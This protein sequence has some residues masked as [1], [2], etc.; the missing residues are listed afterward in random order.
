MSHT[1]VAKRY[2]EAL[3]QIGV[4]KGQLDFLETELTTVREVFQTNEELLEFLTHPKVDADQKKQL[5]NQ[6]FEGFSKD[7]IHTLSLLVDRHNESIVPEIVTH[8]ITLA[9]EEKGMKEATVYSVRALK[10]EEQKQMEQVFVDKLNIQGLKINNIVDP[11]VLGGIRIKIGNT[12][13]DGSIKGKLNRLEREMA[14][15]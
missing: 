7:V 6:A 10:D 2:A 1:V 5:L 4:D 9:Q 12:V 13:Y 11:S 15:S 14:K 8:F 3:F